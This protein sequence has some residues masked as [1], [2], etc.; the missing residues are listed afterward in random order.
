MKDGILCMI[1]ISKTL[2]DVIPKKFL[3]MHPCLDEIQTAK[4]LS[5]QY[6]KRDLYTNNFQKREICILYILNYARHVSSGLQVY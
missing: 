1:V 3:G 5:I 6:I 4:S 2:T